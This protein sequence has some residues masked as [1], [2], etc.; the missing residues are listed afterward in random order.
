MRWRLQPYAVEA[1]TLHGGGCNSVW[2]SSVVAGA[3]K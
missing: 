2:Y 3:L 1:A